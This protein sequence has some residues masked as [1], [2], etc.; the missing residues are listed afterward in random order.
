MIVFTDDRD[1]R[2]KIRNDVIGFAQIPTGR[3]MINGSTLRIVKFI[4]TSPAIRTESNPTRNTCMLLGKLSSTVS[5]LLG[6]SFV[7]SVLF[8]LRG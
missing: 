2:Y 1:I 4:S 8:F 6:L 7:I 5:R 3:G